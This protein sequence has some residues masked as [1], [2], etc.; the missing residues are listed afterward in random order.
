MKK[1]KKEKKWD[2]KEKKEKNIKIG[3]LLKR[4]RSRL[5]DN[6]SSSKPTTIECTAYRLG[7]SRRLIRAKLDTQ[8]WNLNLNKIN[9]IKFFHNLFVPAFLFLFITS[10]SPCAI[11]LRRSSTHSSVCQIAVAYMRMS[12]RI[13]LYANVKSQSLICDCLIRNERMHRGT[14]WVWATNVKHRYKGA[15]SKEGGK[16][17]DSKF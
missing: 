8:V 2:K 4:R 3:L 9:Q 13:F 12:N 10:I 14:N 11:R 16:K 6:V 1:E 17:E 7:H 15:V 5:K